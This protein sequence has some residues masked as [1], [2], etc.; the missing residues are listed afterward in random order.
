M[1]SVCVHSEHTHCRWRQ[2]HCCLAWLNTEHTY[3]RISRSHR[4]RGIIQYKS[5]V[6]YSHFWTDVKLLVPTLAYFPSNAK[7][8]SLLRSPFSHSVSWLH[9]QPLG[10]IVCCF[11]S[12]FFSEPSFSFTVYRLLFTYSLFASRSL[13]FMS[14]AFVFVYHDVLVHTFAILRCDKNAVRLKNLW[15]PKATGSEIG[16]WNTAMRNKKWRQKEK[17]EEN[18]LHINYYVFFVCPFTHSH[19]R[20]LISVKLPFELTPIQ[21]NGM[22]N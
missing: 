4:F 17:T 9:R 22:A 1:S 18:S 20:T 13:C 7:H 15:R 6:V 8:F 14:H 10:L 19:K 5:S 12:S 2:S 16:T 21:C 11:L 3:A